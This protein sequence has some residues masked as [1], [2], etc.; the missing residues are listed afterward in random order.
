[1][2]SE[3]GRGLVVCLTKFYQHFGDDSLRDAY[4]CARILKL[5]EE[6]K[7][8]VMSDSPPSHLNYGRNLNNA[9]KF[10]YTKEVSI[11]KGVEEAMSHKV[12]LWANGASDHLYDIKVPKG[13]KWKG[14]RSAVK[15]LKNT[16]LEMGHGMETRIYTL[17]DVSVMEKL[18][19]DVIIAVDAI[20]GLKPDWGEW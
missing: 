15:R 10:F 12:T 16:G 20:I 18:T 17:Q 7:N 5:S 1:M 6:D 11:W 3:F 13:E 19:K 9:F 4:F 14:V 2:K 8:K